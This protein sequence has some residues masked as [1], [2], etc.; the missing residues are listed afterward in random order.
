[1]KKVKVL[2]ILGVLLAM[3]MTA[4]GN[5]PAEESKPADTSAA[6]PSS[7]TQPS[8]QKP[9]SQPQQSSQQGGESSQSGGSNSLF[10]EVED[11]AP[12]HF[13]AEE[14]VAAD[15][16]AGTVAYKKAAC[17]DT[18]CAFVKIALNQANATFASGSSNKSG[19]PEGYVKLG[20]NNQSLSFKFKTD[21]MYMG[22]FYLLGR[23]D[24]YSTAGNQSAGLYRSGSPNIEVKINGDKI[25]LSSKSSYKYSD[26][27]GTD[28]VSTGLES[29]SNY[30]SHE[31][32][33]EVGN[34][35]LKEG[36]NEL[37]YTRKESQN[38][39]VRDFVFIVEPHTHSFPETWTEVKPA[40][41]TDLGSEERVCVCGAKE[42]RDVNTLAY[43][44]DAESEVIKLNGDGKKTFQ[45]AYNSGAAKV[46]AVPMKQNSGV[47]KTEAVEGTPEAWTIGDNAN[48]AAADTYK[49]D[50]GNALLFK[51]KVSADINNALI[52]IG[53]KYSNARARHFANEG[54]RTET[55]TNGDD[56]TSD[57]YRYYTK[58]NDG[59]FQPIAFN[60]YM[61]EIFGD[62]KSVCYMP[63]GKF[64]LKAGEN[65]I[66]VRQGKLGYR[67]TL[68]GN[69]YVSL[70]DALLDG[71]DPAPAVE[72]A[73]AY[74]TFKW[75]EAIQEDSAALDGTKFNKNASYFLK[76]KNVPAD[77]TYVLTLPMMGS[78]G[79][80][81]KTVN[82]SGQ[83]FTVTVGENAATLLVD[84]KA[85]SEVFGDQTS[86][87]DV[88]FAEVPLVAGTN[89][90]KIATN[91]G[92]YRVSVNVDG[93]I[94]LAA[95]A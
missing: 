34:V 56:P 81:S 67:V 63:L 31:G 71:D 29:P 54:D 49:L 41:Y 2:T 42:Q 57:G 10:E 73:G 95:K 13:G 48:K 45:Y 47:F 26:T 72:V 40:S 62:G 16:E 90:I 66:Y 36:V 38:M 79:N 64:N 55:D 51:V 92:G 76:V 84:G 46:A 82:G 59:E 17:G 5:K 19:T 12:H 77:G 35:V 87:V 8:S 50:Q 60:S 65:L 61:S 28:Y 3:G 75:S 6:Q 25:D 24:G 4:C 20:G 9:S 33:V 74:P 18:D 94:T 83:G 7:Q 32:Y 21:K 80:D 11:P 14:D 23:M 70:G 53:A 52:S 30:L 69:L 88:A 85:Y 15:A 58:V 89:I 91:G 22:K 68:E 1:M 43:N 93:N 37:I 86:W 78:S 44:V 27:W 39:I